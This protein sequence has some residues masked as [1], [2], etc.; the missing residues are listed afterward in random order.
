MI[1][2]PL[3]LALPPA[4][5]LPGWFGLALPDH[6]TVMATTV[7]A[8][9]VLRVH[10][11]YERVDTALLV[12]TAFLDCGFAYH[13]LRNTTPVDAQFFTQPGSLPRSSRGCC[14]AFAL[15]RNMLPFD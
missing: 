3:R 11:V 4:R 7:N 14:P 6:V 12:P 2:G 8:A 9:N 13:R 10:A 15:R 1:H 5:T